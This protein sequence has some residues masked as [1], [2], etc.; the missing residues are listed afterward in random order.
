MLLKIILPRLLATFLL[1]VWHKI[2]GD[3][4][5]INKEC[6]FKGKALYLQVRIHQG[7]CLL[8][9]TPNV[10]ILGTVKVHVRDDIG[11][12]LKIY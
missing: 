12:D 5:K 7:F 11:Q 3:A 2:K 4:K 8:T 1:L 10:S 6:K 9:P